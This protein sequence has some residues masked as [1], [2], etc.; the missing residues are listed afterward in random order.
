MGQASDKINFALG[1]EGWLDLN[2]TGFRAGVNRDEAS[3]GASYGWQIDVV[4]LRLDY[5]AFLPFSDLGDHF[6]HHRFSTSVR[7]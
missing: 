2:R 1:V 7:F 6:G 5:A 3:I 4:T